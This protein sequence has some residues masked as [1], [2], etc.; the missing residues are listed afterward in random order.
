LNEWKNFHF[1]LFQKL[2]YIT[3]NSHESTRRKT[4]RFG[5]L[6]GLF[7]YPLK[8]GNYNRFFD[9]LRQWSWDSRTTLI[10]S[11][12]VRS[13]KLIFKKIKLIS[14]YKKHSK[15]NNFCSVGSKKIFMKQ[16]NMHITS[17]RALQHSWQ[18]PKAKMV[19]PQFSWVKVWSYPNKHNKQIPILIHWYLCD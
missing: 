17:S 12:H 15:I 8:N 3:C 4:A 2:I 9:F 13:Y 10:T 19:V 11:L 6:F 18:V 14:G 16:K 7:F 5:Q 1:W